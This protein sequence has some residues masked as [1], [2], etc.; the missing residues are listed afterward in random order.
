MITEQIAYFKH[1][2]TTMKA[3]GHTDDVPGF[4]SHDLQLML[5]AKRKTNTVLFLP[6]FQGNLK[7]N[8]SDNPIDE[9][10]IQW[11]VLQKMKNENRHEL[12]RVIV[13]TKDIALKIVARML[14]H[15]F[16]DPEG[17]YCQLL[18]YFDLD[19]IEYRTEPIYHDN[20]T[21]IRVITPFVSNLDLTMNP[22]DWN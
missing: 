20:W 7:D 21:G 22:D 12:E 3:I 18:Q 4:F 15:Q 10:R 1:L 5:Q 19:D 17:T 6:Q 13:E 14:W 2:A 8:R 16:E 9:A 11:A